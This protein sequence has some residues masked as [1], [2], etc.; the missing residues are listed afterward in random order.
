MRFIIVLLEPFLRDIALE[1]SKPHHTFYRSTF[2]SSGTICVLL[3]DQGTLY[4]GGF[5]DA[6]Y[7]ICKW[8]FSCFPLGY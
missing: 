1:Y 7:P 2:K 5:D 8:L 4:L 6:C 3:R